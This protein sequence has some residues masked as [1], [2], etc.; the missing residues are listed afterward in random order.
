VGGVLRRWAE[1]CRTITRGE[2]GFEEEGGVD[3]IAEGGGGASFGLGCTKNPDFWTIPL[4]VS[5]L[6][7]IDGRV[8]VRVGDMRVAELGDL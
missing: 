4:S 8:V 7:L 3:C 5:P 1:A 2:S 6:G